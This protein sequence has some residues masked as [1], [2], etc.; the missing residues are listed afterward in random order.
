MCCVFLN[1]TVGV[2]LEDAVVAR[3]DPSAMAW[4]PLHA[5]QAG[6]KKP[7]KGAAKAGHRPASQAPFGVKDGDLFGVLDRRADDPSQ[8]LGLWTASPPP[9]LW[10]TPL[11]ALLR[12]DREAS[13]AAAEDSKRPSQG[14]GSKKDKSRPKEISLNIGGCEW[15]DSDEDSDDT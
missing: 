14:P 1:Q 15:S 13:H 11:D 6:K 2:A 9:H 4:Q 5:A 3:Y 7:K 8:A 12:R 10:E